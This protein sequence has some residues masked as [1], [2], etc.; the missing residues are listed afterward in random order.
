MQK[1]FGFLMRF[2][3]HD[4]LDP[5]PLLEIRQLGHA[6]HGDPATRVLGAARG[7]A[8]RHPAFR[9]LVDH[10][11]EFARSRNMSGFRRYVAHFADAA[12]PKPRP[13]RPDQLFGVNN[14]F[15]A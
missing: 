7:E 13:A 10:D 14:A 4:F 1:A 2:I 6:Q 15:N 9:R 3:A 11:E 5:A 12:I 8:D